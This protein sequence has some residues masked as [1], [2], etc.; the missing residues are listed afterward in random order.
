MRD[1]K[2]RGRAGGARACQRQMSVHKR[3]H[4]LV[5]SR[6]DRAPL[7]AYVRSGPSGIAYRNSIDG[8]NA[9]IFTQRK[10]ALAAPYQVIPDVVIG[11][12]LVVLKGLYADI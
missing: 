2:T 9:H 8:N 7:L 5:P 3:L 12:M 11:R 4:G 6:D 1:S 10:V